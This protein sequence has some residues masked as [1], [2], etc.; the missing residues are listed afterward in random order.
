MPFANPKK[1]TKY[2]KKYR[3]ENAEHIAEVSHLNYQRKRAVRR[4]AREARNRAA[5]HK[6]RKKGPK[7]LPEVPV[8]MARK[9]RLLNGRVYFSTLRG[10]TL[11]E[12]REIVALIGPGK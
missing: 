7:A 6:P 4:K 9:W 8:A 12:L 5:G 2:H 11:E 3:E 10:F 1:K